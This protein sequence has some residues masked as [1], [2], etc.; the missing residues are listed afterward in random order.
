MLLRIGLVIASAVLGAAGG[1]EDSESAVIRLLREFTGLEDRP[2]AKP[3]ETVDMDLMLE[4][5]ESG[6]VTF[7]DADWFVVKEDEDE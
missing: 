4:L 5:V 6:W 3:I 1:A 7:H 2:W